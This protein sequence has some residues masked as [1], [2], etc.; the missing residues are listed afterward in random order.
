MT[1]CGHWQ[2]VQIQYSRCIING[3]RFHTRDLDERRKSQNNGMNAEGLHNNQM[4]NYF[5]HLCNVWEFEYMCGNKVVLF[6]CE[7]YDT[8]ITGR[9]T[10]QTDAH[11]SSVDVTIKW[12]VGDPFILPSQAKQVFYLNDTNVGK[13]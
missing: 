1:N 5:H 2:M 3:V 6:E 13:N 12:Y 4:P 7:W 9:R 8:S 11:C 10:I